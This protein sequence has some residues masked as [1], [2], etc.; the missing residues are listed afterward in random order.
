MRS[1]LK[2]DGHQG[3][4]RLFCAGPRVDAQ[5]RHDWLAATSIGG[6][7]APDVKSLTAV[8]SIPHQMLEKVRPIIEPGTTLV[9]TDLPVAYQTQLPGFPNPGDECGPLTNSTAE[10]HPSGAFFLRL[11]GRASG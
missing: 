3:K 9:I 7:K 1:K 11:S 10:R 5:G 2:E 8:T 4:P 6:G